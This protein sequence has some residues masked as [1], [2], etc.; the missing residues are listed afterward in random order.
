[1]D[2]ARLAD[3]V[4]MMALHL[5]GSR[6]AQVR[7]ISYWAVTWCDITCWPSSLVQTPI[8]LS[9]HSPWYMTLPPP[10]FFSSAS[11]GILRILPKMPMFQLYPFPKHALQVLC[12]AGLNF[13]NEEG[14]SFS[15]QL[16]WE[17]WTL[18][19][20]LW[21]ITLLSVTVIRTGGSSMLMC[22]GNGPELG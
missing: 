17:I 6:L 3:K 8:L 20:F 5:A 15:R 18:L 14:F 1:M 7:T 9:F 19:W 22:P 2:Q 10:L 4:R 13:E 12:Q 11:F 16:W 21:E